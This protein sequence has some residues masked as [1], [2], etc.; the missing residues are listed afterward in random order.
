MAT[1]ADRGGTS[2]C[3]YCDEGTLMKNGASEKRKVL[4]VDDHPLFCEGLGHVIN[5]QPDL[6]MCG[7]AVDGPGGL[8]AARKLKPAVVV[9]DLTLEEG[10][11]LEM[12]QCLHAEQPKLPILAL[13]AHHEDVY[14]VRAFCAGARGYVMKHEPV[15]HVLAALRKLL[16]GQM[17]FSENITTQVMERGVGCGATVTHSPVE[18]LSNRELEIYRAIGSGR[19]TREIAARLGLAV[20]TVESYRSSI[21]QKLHLRNAAELISG[22]ARFLAE[23]TTR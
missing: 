8:A 2:R 15:S 20:S 7:E 4:I 21:K 14:A 11:G 16:N 10:S 19:G 18:R 17:A 5:Q 1:N 13:S 22:A 12:I 6:V 23:E 9:A 3:S